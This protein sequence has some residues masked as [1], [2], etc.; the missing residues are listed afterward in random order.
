[1]RF[2]TLAVHAGHSPDSATG[3]VA[4]PLYLSTTFERAADGSFP[5]GFVYI[6]D[7][8]PNRR[9]LEE[10][11]AALEGG[12][13]CAAFASGMAA[14]H[15]IFQ[16]LA[17]GDRVL[18]PEDAYY[19]TSKIV[20]EMLSRWGLRCDA[21]DA[22]NLDAVRRALETPARLLWVETPSNPR[23]R[24][25]DIA[26]V[27]ELAHGAGALVVCDNTW[28]TPALTRPLE[29]G[30]D[31][32][33]HSTTKYLGGHSD[34]QG[35]AVVA[36]VED[37][38]FQSVRLAQTL[39]GGVPSPFDCWLVLRGARSLAA[40]LRVHC[41]NAATVARFL[42]GH[43]AVS[44]VHYPGL[45]SH[46]GHAVAA[47]Q[48][49]AFGGMLSFEVAGGRATAMAAAGRLRVITR[50][51]S[52]GGTESL[53]EHRASIEGALTRAPEGLLRMSVGLEHP[54]DIV[55]DLDQALRGS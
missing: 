12:A 34:V 13:V 10:C 48:M 49:G 21:V 41:E 51:T 1:M 3:A 6:R 42:L 14:T 43:P 5:S 45:P 11:L 20:R 54:E 22:T 27:S 15:A 38:L 35:G 23:L 52:L 33:M 28:A 32:V 30:A 25:T 8:N 26:A 29:L 44:G 50:A 7:A 40:R 37:R 55:A 16:S 46:P 31:L 2:E 19:A 53:I 9:M 18:L 17:P 39:A 47:R 36:R 4:P 24:V